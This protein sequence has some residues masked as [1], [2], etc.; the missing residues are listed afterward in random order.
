MSDF[1]TCYLLSSGDL[2]EKTIAGNIPRERE[3]EGEGNSNISSY[4]MCHLE[5][6]NLLR[7]KNKHL[8][9][10]SGLN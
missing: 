10:N 7:L 3:E 5:A 2:N 6:G 4:G 9:P 8:V 1:K